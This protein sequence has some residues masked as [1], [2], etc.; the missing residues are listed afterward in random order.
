MVK[1]ADG[2]F[3]AVSVDDSG[4][5]VSTLKQISNDDVADVSINAGEKIIEGTITAATLNVNDIFA[6]NA[7]IR[8]LIAANLDVDTL[9]AR[10]ATL[11]ALNAMDITG[12]TYLKL[13]VA[14]KAEQSALDALEERVS[15]AELKITAD[16][17]V[18]TVTGSSTYLDAQKKIYDDMDALLGYRLE[19]LAETVFLSENK[20]NTTLTAHVWHGN[21]EVTDSIAAERF[22]WTR[23]SEDA[24]ADAVWNS[25]HQGFK[26]ILVT[27]ADVLRQASFRCELTE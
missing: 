19:I 26:S 2:H 9:F 12:N 10:E 11:T 3:Y 17:I 27:T 25:A 20:R 8:S 21:T 13:M 14:G 16:A 1:G 23:E 4:N 18:S 5:V 7:I 22:K 24:T 6:N 15:N